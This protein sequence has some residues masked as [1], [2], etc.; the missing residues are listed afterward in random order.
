M[1]NTIRNLSLLAIMAASAPAQAQQKPAVF[2]AGDRISF[3]GNSITE[4]GFYGLYIWQYYQLHFPNERILVMNKGIGGDVAA[5]ILAR[6]EDDVLVKKPT[7]IVLTFGMN[8]S[9]YFEYYNA[10]E[11]SVRNEAIATSLKNYEA[12]EKKLLAL[13]GVKKVIMTSSPYDETMGGNKNRF[14]GKYKTMEGIARFQEASAVKNKWGFVDLM[15]PMQAINER[16]QK[17]DTNYTLTGPDR[18]HPGNAGHMAMAWLFLKNQG[19]S[20][21]VVADVSV[22]AR[23]ARLQRSVN[24]KVSGLKKTATGVS[25]SYLAKSLPFPTDSNTRVWENPQRQYEALAVIPFTEEMNRENLQVTGLDESAGYGLLIDGQPVADFTGK[26]LASGI[27][28]AL[29]SNTPQYQQAKQVAELNF[30]YRD[31]EQKL[32]AYVWLQTN[33]FRPRKM[34]YQDDQ[35]ALDS[36]L[37][38]APKDWAVASKKDNYVEGR[39]KEVR[40]GW[41]K[42]MGTIM[43]RIYTINKPRERKFEI[44]LKK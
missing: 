42:E 11:T 24:A 18:I 21:T 25:F 37:A 30:Q 35:V 19:L 31:L 10:P 8:D 32:R 17:R 38:A 44:R 1:K 2:K 27:N 5:G 4:N 12:I 41:E 20:G 9:R 28:L 23:T 14:T 40:A 34:M 22:N 7:V 13:P 36:I 26:E 29:L 15:R 43:D 6:L 33:Y 39:K 3:T 16:E